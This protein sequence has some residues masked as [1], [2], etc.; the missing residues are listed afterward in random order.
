MNKPFIIGSRDSALAQWQARQVQTN[1]KQSVLQTNIKWIKSIGDLVQNQPLHTIG[2][3]GV[4]TK[5]LDD[6]LLN[7]EIDMA[8]HSCKDLPSQLHPELRICAYLP[9]EDSADVIVGNG[10]LDFLSDSEFSGTIATGSVRRK[11]QI[12]AKFPKATVVGLRGNVPT[13]LQKLKES[14]WHGAVFALAGLKRLSLSPTF[15]QKA[16]F[17]VPA[18]AQ[19]VVA[20][21][22]R[23]NDERVVKACQ[24]INHRSTEVTTNIERKFLRLMEGGCIS[25]IGAHAVIRGEHVEV[26]ISVL[27]TD[28]TEKIEFSNTYSSSAVE[29]I[30][31]D[32]F[33]K[34]KQKGAVTLIE[35]IERS[36]A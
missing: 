12:L 3:V 21:V 10:R 35:K 8:V 9:R 15:L 26:S 16:E 4:F 32:M 13:R 11:A 33:E 25:P 6:A 27:H 7:N 31:D 20:I 5:A 14:N 17:M 23:K 24:T 28:G 19:G 34:A 2:T 22:C 29:H 36:N 18:P 1:L 30:A